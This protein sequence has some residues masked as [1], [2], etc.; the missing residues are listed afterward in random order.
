MEFACGKIENVFGSDYKIIDSY[1][2]RVR[3]PMPPYLLANRVTEMNAVK[4]EFKPSSIT[5]EYDVPLDAWFSVDGQIP[6]AIAV[7]A[8]QCDLLLISYLGIDFEAKGVSLYRLLDCTLT[9]KGEMP[10]Q[11]DRMRYEIKTNSFARHG[12]N[13]LFF[14]EYE[15]FV[16]DQLVH[17][18][19]DG[20]AG[21]FSEEDLAKGQGVI[22]TK[23]ELEERAQVVKQNFTPFI[24]T[25]RKSFNE[26]ELLSLCR[27]NISACLGPAFDQGN[28][29]PSL[30]FSSEEF[31]MLDRI[32]DVDPSGGLWGLGQV[33]AIKDLKP[34][35]WF[36]SC[37]FKDDNCLAGSLMAEGCVQLLEFYLLYIGIQT[38]TVNA[39][40]QPIR[41][42]ANKV[43]CRGQ[44][45]PGDPAISYRMEVT[46]LSLSP[47]PYAKAN[48]EIL[49]EGKI[50]VDFQDVGIELVEKDGPA[51]PPAPARRM[52]YDDQA[53]HEFAL[54]SIS[55]AFGPEYAVLESR[56]HQRNP[57]RELQ[58]VHR[59]PLFE[60]TR[61]QFG[62]TSYL[63]SEYDVK[64]GDWY[65]T[66][67]PSGVMPYAV[68][69]EIA[70]QPCG[71]LGAVMGSPLLF[72]DVELCFRNLDG[73]AKLHFLPPA[74]DQTITAKVWLDL[75]APAANTIVQRYRFEL[76]SGGKLFFDGKT[77]FGYFT[78]DAFT[79]QKGMDKGEKLPPWILSEG[80]SG[81]IYNLADEAACPLFQG[82]SQAKLATGWLNFLDSAE[83][84]GSG[85]KYGKGYVYA[86]KKVD[87]SD[88]FYP[89]HFHEDSVMPGSLG[90][91]AIIQ[92]V[93]VWALD[94]G[95]TK[96][97]TRP[98]F[99]HPL[100]EAQWKYSGQIIPTNEAMDL[101]TSII[102][103]V[104]EPGKTIIWAE[105]N[106]FKDKIRIYH[107]ARIGV[108]IEEA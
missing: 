78:P 11:G 95:L 33:T 24:S 76:W 32:I 57:N 69:M 45:V 71:V 8:G 41:D 65:F 100:D 52:D 23:K 35:D 101:E 79:T 87:P 54:G 26:N 39:R 49:L 97:F 75:T 60:G 89:M 53:I 20:C 43:R 13:L 88:W 86:M 80:K 83:V 30:R 16:G 3:L 19:T 61:Q 63:E 36:F 90:V 107:I 38:H 96:N 50:V 94:Q 22:M 72:P 92:A 55:K 17:T 85:G 81:T 14:F 18:M 27:G 40:F 6:W 47:R 102:E 108:Q 46:E 42:L 21:F 93:K 2:P 10:K 77:T 51:G 1:G 84:L 103:V 59:V 66:K 37:H 28:K 105:A 99:S 31:L 104:R 44:V 91:E 68:I 5:T 82:I 98:R 58:L 4:G 25:D 64:A 67:Q 15:C 56:G 34:D 106:L 12:H 74:T 29:N 9:F 70:L 73:Q 7:E 62:K 48:V